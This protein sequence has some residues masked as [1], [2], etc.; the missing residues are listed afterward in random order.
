MCW[1]SGLEY[2]DGRIKGTSHSSMAVASDNDICTKIGSDTL[3]RGGS[4]VDSAISVLI[5]LGAVQP[6][7]NGIG[8]GGFMI[9][10][11]RNQDEVINFREVAPKASTP[12]MFVGD[13]IT[14]SLSLN[15]GMASGVP[16]S[17]AGYWKAHT[18]F[19]KLNWADLFAP[20]IALLN[21]TF[22]VSKHMAYALSIMK[23]HL[24][25]DKNARITFFK[26]PYDQESY[27]REDDTYRNDKL[28]TTLQLI[29]N[30]GTKA[31]YEGKI[32]RN[33]VK[34]TR[35]RGGIMTMEDLA[36][37]K[38]LLQE[39]LQFQYRSKNILS[40][41]PPASGHILSIVLQLLDN[42]NLTSRDARAW[43][44]IIEA[45]R[46]GYAV[47]GQTG[48][49]EFSERTKSL[50]EKIQNGTWAEEILKDHADKN[51]NQ[52]KGPYENVDRYMQGEPL[53]ENIAGT[54][55]THVSVLGPDGSAVSCTSSVNKFF[56]SRIM[57][58]DGFI[59][60]SQMNDFAT[61][62]AVNS[63]G[64][65]AAPENFIVPGK[66][67]MSSASPSIILDEDGRTFT[68]GGEGG[69]RIITSTVQSIINIL[70][71]DMDLEESLHAKRL[72]D[73]LTMATKYELGFDTT[74]V[75]ELR[76]MGYN[77]VE[78]KGIM[79]CVNSVSSLRR[80]KTEAS[81]DPRKGGSGRVVAS[82]REYCLPWFKLS[83]D[84][85][86]RWPN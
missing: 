29:S 34:A 49:P 35:A 7:S 83:S 11:T 60:N 15:S 44:Q 61:L 23:R 3:S 18:L 85:Q 10:H 26:N 57:T 12:E 38:V 22:P 46:F 82:K 78:H 72:H 81:G 56:G 1:D 28:A 69:S 86:R 43:S 31:F 73:K 20:T 9:V 76:K 70:D 33:I 25:K 59:M 66:R 16:G 8:G 41:P 55:T 14:S 5:C 6:Q 45:F 64:F 48:D 32:A 37:Y 58:D 36:E 19:G 21:E 4:A 71:W 77:M 75:E 53:Y 80:G 65:P 52:F 67:P 51:K 54:H 50:L 63:Y 40:V 17:L 2:A 74:L 30:H 84:R 13:D 62:G 47:R 24:I 79:S 42:C 27:L 39:P 68:T